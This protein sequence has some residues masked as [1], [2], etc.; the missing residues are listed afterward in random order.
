MRA[1]DLGE[2]CYEVRWNNAREVLVKW[3]VESIHIN[4]DKRYYMLKETEGNGIDIINVDDIQLC[5]L[6]EEEVIKAL[7]LYSARQQECV[8]AA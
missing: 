4:G 8:E 3:I 6:L 1:P 5:Y 7:N 2:Y